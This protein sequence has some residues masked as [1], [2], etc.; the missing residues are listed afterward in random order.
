MTRLASAKEEASTN[1]HPQR[2][3]FVRSLEASL[4]A[5][6]RA[7]LFLGTSARACACACAEESLT[8]SH[9][10]CM[11]AQERACACMLPCTGCPSESACSCAHADAWACTCACARACAPACAPSATPCRRA[12]DPTWPSRRCRAH[13]PRARPA[14]TSHVVRV[15]RISA[16]H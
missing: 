11:G 3:M 5:P 2:C 6:V 15:A 13:A 4:P 8:E 14:Q 7:C 10:P 1:M 16:G 12:A 9:H